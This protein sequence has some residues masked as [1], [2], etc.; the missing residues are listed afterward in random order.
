LVSKFGAVVGSRQLERRGFERNLGV[1]AIPTSRASG[2]PTLARTTRELSAS[3]TA[4][5]LSAPHIS[6]IADNRLLWSR[7]ARTVSV[8]TGW[9]LELCH[10]QTV[11]PIKHAKAAAAARNTFFICRPPFR[12]KHGHHSAVVQG[13]TSQGGDAYDLGHMMSAKARAQRR[14]LGRW[15]SLSR[16]CQADSG[17]IVIIRANHD[18][19]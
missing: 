12:S 10:T 2:V 14:L 9:P 19:G 1:S 18:R 11:P 13:K 16:P 3:A 6:L 8:S 5:G 17:T 7:I 4:A 15:V